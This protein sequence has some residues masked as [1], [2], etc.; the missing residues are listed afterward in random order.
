MTFPL[1]WMYVSHVR[2]SIACIK[3][4]TFN[5]TLLNLFEAYLLNI[6]HGK[7]LV[8]NSP[9]KLLCIFSSSSVKEERWF[10][11]R[12]FA[13]L[14]DSLDNIWESYILCEAVI[15]KNLNTR[16]H[17]QSNWHIDWVVDIILTSNDLTCTDFTNVAW[18]YWHWFIWFIILSIDRC[19]LLYHLYSRKYWTW[20]QAI[21]KTAT[22]VSLW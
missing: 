3:F 6:P 8:D 15:E 19:T 2:K 14:S 12:W 9:M 11:R 1:G 10:F 13:F 21:D 16:Y 22:T 4:P 5:A 17:A 7:T 18:N 20:Q